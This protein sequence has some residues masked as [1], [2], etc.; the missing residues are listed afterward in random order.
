M[1]D[2]YSATQVGTQGPNSGNSATISQNFNN[3]SLGID[4][5]ELFN[6][7]DKIK[8]HLKNENENEENDILIGEVTKALKMIKEEKK[9]EAVG[10]IKSIG[11]KLYDIAKSIGCSVVAKII[12]SEMGL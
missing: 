7:L 11:K 5:L 8:L 1:R 4:F 6:E 2:V 9:Q 10:H 3:N 12:T